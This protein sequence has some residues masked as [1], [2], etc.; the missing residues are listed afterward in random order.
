MSGHPLRETVVVHFE[1]AEI[2]AA[3]TDLL[4]A[5]G[6]RTVAPGSLSVLDGCPRIVTEP[7][8]YADLDNDQQQR[9]L[10]VGNS[11]HLSNIDACSLARPLTENK[12]EK[13]ICDLLSL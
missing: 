5:I 3:F 4:G 12:I 10:V 2:T 9:C 7:R 11:E 13:A 6:M 8:F 1:D